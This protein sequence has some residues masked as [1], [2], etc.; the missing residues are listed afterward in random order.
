MTGCWR[1]LS[2]L[3]L[4]LA[5]PVLL[6]VPFAQLPAAVAVVGIEALVIGAVPFGLAFLAQTLLGHRHLGD[7][8]LLLL[9]VS[10]ACAWWFLGQGAAI[11]PGEGAVTLCMSVLL[12]LWFLSLG[13]V[14]ARALRRHRLSRAPFGQREA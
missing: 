4:I 11:P 9:A 7:A 10:V 6:R 14:S 13:A 5:Y 2:G 8:A 1:I 12:L 3:A